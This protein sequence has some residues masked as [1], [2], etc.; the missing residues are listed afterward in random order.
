[1]RKPETRYAFAA[2][3]CKLFEK[4]E[5]KEAPLLISGTALALLSAAPDKASV[6][7]AFVRRFYPNSWWGSLAD[8]LETRLT[9]FDQLAAIK[10]EAVMLEIE[11]AKI[12]YQNRIKAE[13][14]SEKKEQKARNSSFE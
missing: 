5:N 3:V 1:M 10:D 11:N 14:E 6:I 9:L 7:Q 13:R 4:Q 8:T 12:A 2:G